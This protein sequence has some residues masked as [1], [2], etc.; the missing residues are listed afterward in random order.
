MDFRPAH[1]LPA[2]RSRWLDRPISS[3]GPSPPA[4]HTRPRQSRDWRLA[5]CRVK[6]LSDHVTDIEI[7]GERVG[8][9]QPD[10]AARAAM[11]FSTVPVA[12]GLTFIAVP[13][14]A[15]SRG[16]PATSSRR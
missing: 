10:L 8:P 12:E 7:L 3:A 11:L 15:R 6:S 13:S 9:F 2:E 14:P 1:D 4:F 16:S 5:F